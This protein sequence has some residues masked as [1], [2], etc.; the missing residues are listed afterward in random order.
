MPEEDRALARPTH[1][2][3]CEYRVGH[4]DGRYVWVWDHC[5]L[6][7]DCAGVIVRVVGTVLD[8]TERKEIHMRLRATEQR[9]RDSLQRLELAMDAASIGMWDWDLDSGRMTFTR[10]THLITGISEADFSGRPE[11]FFRLLLPAD[12]DHGAQFLRDIALPG[13]VRQSEL[14]I[15][16]PDGT[17]CGVQNRATAI[18]DD[19]GRMCGIVGTLAVV[20]RPA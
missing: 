11:D 1:S 7:R 9:L 18:V 6:V 5:M 14:R 4:K 19:A 16:R 12:I 15:R 2:G 3:S 20:R 13:V 8:I 10:Q 17:E